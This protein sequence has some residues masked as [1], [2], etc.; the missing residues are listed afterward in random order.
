MCSS[1]M[2]M[3]SLREKIGKI[4]SGVWRFS[5][6]F[7]PPAVINKAL[8]VELQTHDHDISG[9]AWFADLQSYTKWSR[10]WCEIECERCVYIQRMSDSALCI[11]VCVRWYLSCPVF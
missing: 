7:P 3:G 5:W 1:G 11:H 2:F 8:E 6:V 10:V 4:R 9:H